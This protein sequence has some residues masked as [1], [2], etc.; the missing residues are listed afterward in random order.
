MREPNRNRV[1]V[2][3]TAAIA[4]LGGS[5]CYRHVPAP[6]ADTRSG[7]AVTVQVRREDV[8]RTVALIGGGAALAAFLVTSAFKSANDTLAA[9][10][11][12]PTGALRAGLRV[13]VRLP[14]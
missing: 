6:V 10:A 5:A 11:P 8:P 3:R 12:R 2:R 1:R 14:F 13:P 9:P 7:A 4:A